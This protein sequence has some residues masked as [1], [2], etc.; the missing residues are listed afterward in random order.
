MFKNLFIIG[1]LYLVSVQGFSQ[2]KKNR[3]APVNKSETFCKKLT[4]SLENMAKNLP[5][6]LALDTGKVPVYDVVKDLKLDNT[7]ATLITAPFQKAIDSCAKIG[8][9]R[10]L[11]PKGTYLTGTI[12]LRS[13]VHIELAHLAKI[14]GSVDAKDYPVIYPEYKAN[15]DL[16]VNKSLFYAEKV[17]NISFTGKGMIDFRGDHEVY[18]NTGNNDPRRPFGIRIV[19]SKNI[20]VAGLMFWNSPQW[21]QHYLNCENLMIEKMSVFNHAHQN[22]DGID[23]D[24]CRNV[25]LR[26]NRVDSDDDGIC[27]KSNGPAS[28]E[29]V[30]VENCTVSSHCNA[31]KLGTET[32]GG[33][34][35]IIYRN[36]KVIQSVTADH[37]VNGAETARTAITL[38]ITDGGKME[39]VWFDNITAEDCVSPIFV[40]LGN[41][42]RRHTK[43][44]PK[45]GIGTMENVVISNIKAIGA[46][47]MPSS[48]T[49]LDN[50]HVIKNLTLE[51]IILE[52]AYTG[53]EENRTTDVVKVLQR[54]KGG[55]PSPDGWG[56]LNASGLYCGF[57]D[58]LTLKNVIVKSTAKEPR[59]GVVIEN[60]TNVKQVN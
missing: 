57:V 31:L 8:P 60:C 25:Y 29:N 27:L 1:C 26:N 48:V 5:L 39:N 52:Q 3:F 12:I 41:R 50:S 19:S 20:Y 47:P 36:C 2:V 21:M 6:K 14:I 56:N 9:A 32:T 23:I 54:V 40:T 34:R 42:S 59:K 11:F 17:E 51:N 4:D 38:I 22:N 43:D 49:G 24:G 28:C 35:N 33:F 37:H 44:A 10:F 46:G 45:P 30:L 53:K 16:Q 55:Y 13:G 7:G 18:F 15:T 58:G